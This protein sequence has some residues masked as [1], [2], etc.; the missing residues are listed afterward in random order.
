MEMEI[1]RNTYIELENHSLIF[2]GWVSL[3]CH[4]RLHCFPIYNK[5][6][7]HAKEQ[8]KIAMCSVWAW[9]NRNGYDPTSVQWKISSLIFGCDKDQCVKCANSMKS[10]NNNNDERQRK[11]RKLKLENCAKQ[12]DL[13]EHFTQCQSVY[14]DQPQS[15]WATGELTASDGL[16][17][18]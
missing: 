16:I 9:A 6:L 10:N 14:A 8:L 5:S 13:W 11:R 7:T 1:E 2:C 15:F 3:H 12:F 17:Y 18:W 4:Y